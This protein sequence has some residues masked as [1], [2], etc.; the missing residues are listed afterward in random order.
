MERSKKIKK[1]DSG[2]Q[3]QYNNSSYHQICYCNIRVFSILRPIWWRRV[4]KIQQIHGTHSRR[5][6]EFLGTPS[7]LIKNKSMPSITQ[8]N[9]HRL[10]GLLQHLLVILKKKIFMRQFS[11]TFAM[12][13]RVNFSPSRH[14]HPNIKPHTMK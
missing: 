8:H 10:Q 5:R 13:V 7:H 11:K 14:F 4:F 2:D 12:L 1:G 3:E 9:S 6:W